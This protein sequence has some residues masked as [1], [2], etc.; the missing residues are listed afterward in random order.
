MP[1]S[2]AEIEKMNGR[3]AAA[4]GLADLVIAGAAKRR[5]TLAIVTHEF[6]P[7]VASHAVVVKRDGVVVTVLEGRKDAPMVTLNTPLC[8]I[9][10]AY[11]VS[12]A[13]L[14]KYPPD[15]DRGE[16]Q[17]ALY[18]GPAGDPVAWT[19]DMAVLDTGL[20][21]EFAGALARDG[22]CIPKDVATNGTIKKKVKSLTKE[23]FQVWVEDQL[24]GHG[25]PHMA[26]AAKRI[27]D[28]N[29]KD[30]PFQF[31]KK[32]FPRA[33]TNIDTD[34][35]ALVGTSE[36]FEMIR[37]SVNDPCGYAPVPIYVGGK[38]VGPDEYE[39]VSS[40]LAGSVVYLSLW[41][42][43]FTNTKNKVVSLKVGL[44]KIVVSSLGATGVRTD[45]V[46]DVSADTA[47]V[48]DSVLDVVA[49]SDPKRRRT[50]P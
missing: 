27:A 29:D 13:N 37:S 50:G 46:V 34:F 20:V 4:T 21:K 26:H 35:D 1:Q 14:G 41:C 39:S 42:K 8:T 25:S 23:E 24:T 15:A 45:S 18:V 12:P 31:K 44:S 43:L 28:W 47:S 6:L 36:R 5:E 48:V 17:A 7:G 30:I 3:I 40:R 22:T 2:H 10:A 32:L 16:P 19:R 33:E 49:D 11:S 38:L 9:S